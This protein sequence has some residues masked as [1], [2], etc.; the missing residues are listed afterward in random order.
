MI[1][2]INFIVLI[3]SS[4]MFTIY[5]IKSVSP[6]T[7]S[8]RMGNVAFQRCA[9]YRVIASIFM[10]IAGINYILYYWFPLPLSIART[11][12]WPWWVSAVLAVIIAIP[13]GWLVAQ[14]IK[15]A[16][17]ETVRP[18]PEHKMY[19]GIYLRMRHPQAV[20]EFPFWWVLALLAHSPF[21]M[22]FTFLYIP[23]WYW[24]YVV[25]EK[26]LLLRFGHAY[27]EYRKKTGFW[28]TRKK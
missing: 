24:F 15:D 5:Y 28:F 7:L 22:L 21:L 6:V 18:K 20:G 26:D 12:P 9:T 3:I 25:E 2:T 11:F 13:S 8:K 14:G 4:I 1:A 27:E 17:E 10:T 16:G 19:G 23:I